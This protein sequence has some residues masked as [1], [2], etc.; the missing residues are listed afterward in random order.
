MAQASSSC[1]SSF[2]NFSPAGTPDDNLTK[3][4]GWM[5]KTEEAENVA[6][7]FNVPAICIPETSVSAPVITVR[8]THGGQ[9]SAQVT[10][11]KPSVQPTKLTEAVVRDNGRDR[12]KTVIGVASQIET[13]QPVVHHIEAV[14]DPYGRPKLDT[15]YEWRQPE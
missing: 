9:C 1:V 8:L 14:N 5:D 2:R 3:V 11:L 6:P 12:T 4:A 15:T 7:P 10:D 13:A